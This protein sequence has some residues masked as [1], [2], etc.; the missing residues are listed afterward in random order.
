MTKLHTIYARRQDAVVTEDYQGPLECGAPPWQYMAKLI[1]ANP[2]EHVSVLWLG[3]RCHM[4]VDEHGHAKAAP[5]NIIASRIYFNATLQRLEKDEYIFDDFD[6]PP[7]LDT[8]VIR[9]ILTDMG[10]AVIV[11]DAV[12]W[13]GGLE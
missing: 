6:Q 7:I 9:E 4:W 12:L 3:R 11:G 10:G 8:I 2:I 1:G 5:I 13:E